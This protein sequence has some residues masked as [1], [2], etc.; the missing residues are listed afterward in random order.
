MSVADQPP[1]DERVR[2]PPRRGWTVGR[3]LLALAYVT[4]G[5]ALLA[6]GVA[7]VELVR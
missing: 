3:Q 4:A 7:L 6:A 2:R 5:A 1:H